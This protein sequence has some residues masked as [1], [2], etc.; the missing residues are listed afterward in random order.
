MPVILPQ[1]LIPDGS[2]SPLKTD[3]RF[4][5]CACPKCGKP[6]KR[7]TDTM[8]TFV[9]SSWYYMRYTSPNTAPDYHDKMVSSCNDYWMP[10]DQYIGGI[11]HAV[12]HLLYAR[13]WTKAMRDLGMLKF[14]EPFTNLLCQGMVLNHIYYRKSDKGGIE[15]FAPDDVNPVV[16]ATGKPASYRSKTDGLPV[17]YDGV[18]TMS[19]SKLNGVDPQQM[20]DHYGADAARL[21]VMFASPPEQTIE[22]SSAGVEGTHRYLRRLW[23]FC[24]FGTVKSA[25]AHVRSAG[26]ILVPRPEDDR[27]FLEIRREIHSALAQITYDFNRLQ[28]NTVVSGCMKILNALEKARSTPPR[29][30][31]IRSFVIVDGLSILLRALYPACPHITWQL[32]NDLG[33]ALEH[34]DIID[35]PWPEPDPAALEQ[36]EIEMVVQVNGKLRGSIRVPK[37]ATTEMIEQMALADPGVVRHLDGRPVK[38]VIVVPGKLVNV[39]V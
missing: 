9:D 3:E 25:L 35:A 15:Y 26:F 38:R 31:N 29:T 12:L 18:G 20:I 28:Y 27:P 5:N 16:D 1:D 37:A 17:V 32:W 10:M 2:G 14:D 36:D 33:F 39:V 34:G 21:F 19:K 4:L 13:F 11:T 24:L 7:E 6:A 23:D 30:E 8:D 22:W